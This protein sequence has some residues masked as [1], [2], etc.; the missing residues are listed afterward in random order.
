[1]KTIL[2]KI[3]FCFCI[4]ISINAC[5]T[6]EH[7]NIFINNINKNSSEVLLDNKNKKS[8]L[9]V[10]NSIRNNEMAPINLPKQTEKVQKV[11]LQKQVKIPRTDNFS[12][13]KFINWNEKKLIKTLGNSHFVKE[14]GKLKNYQYHFKECFID[15]F[16]LKK[17]E[18]YLVN[19]VETRPTK[20]N[21][22]I[23]INACFE[24]IKQNLN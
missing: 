14:E 12:L 13:D 5:H 23:N 10:K 20:L 3:I 18:I 22:K 11:A 9:S 24:E 19:Y 1:M 7:Q 8:K 2:I 21:G 6:F 15:I 4:V 16:L 17:N